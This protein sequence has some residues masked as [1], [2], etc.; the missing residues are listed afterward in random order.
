[1]HFRKVCALTNSRNTNIE[2]TE[3]EKQKFIA[4]CNAILS[5]NDIAQAI[6]RNLC[7]VEIA[8]VHHGSKTVGWWLAHPETL[9]DVSFSSS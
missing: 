9:A 2:P 6:I 5:K 8:S 4:W 7:G 1:M 3:V